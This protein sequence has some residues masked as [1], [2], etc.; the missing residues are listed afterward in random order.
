MCVHGV[1]STFWA[2][3]IPFV[4]PVVG[5]PLQL[6]RREGRL[7]LIRRAHP[8]SSTVSVE[9]DLLKANLILKQTL[10]WRVFS[11]QGFESG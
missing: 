11:K 8:E 1:F 10:R 3:H 6:T 4:F 2:V 7:R 5:L 9:Q